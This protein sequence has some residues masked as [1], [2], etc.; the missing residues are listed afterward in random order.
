VQTVVQPLSCGDVIL[1]LNQAARIVP[2]R[3]MV[4]PYVAREGA[5]ERHSSADKHRHASDDETLHE[6]RAQEPLN[7]DP[8]VDIEVVGTTS[9]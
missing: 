1:A 6:P 8:T 7:R 2:S 9:S 5:E 4:E 3:H